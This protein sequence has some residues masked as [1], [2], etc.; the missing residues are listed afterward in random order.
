M[1]ESYRDRSKK[2]FVNP[3]R[4]TYGESINLGNLEKDLCDLVSGFYQRDKTDISYGLNFGRHTPIIITGKN[5]AEENLSPFQLPYIF[6]VNDVDYIAIDLREYVNSGIKKVHVESYADLIQYVPRVDNLRTLSRMAIM[7]S[8]LA[9]GDY[10]SFPIDYAIGAYVNLFSVVTKGI[11]TLSF[12]EEVDLKALVG[13]F[14]YFLLNPG[15]PDEVKPETIVRKLNRLINLGLLKEE[16]LKELL[17]GF[18]QTTI[19][20][21]DDDFRKFRTLLKVASEYLPSDKKKFFEPSIFINRVQNLW[22]GPGKSQGVVTGFECLPI[23]LPI[24]ESAVSTNTFKN[25]RLTSI[26]LMNKNLN[27]KDFSKYMEREF[28]YLKK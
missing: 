27:H 16:S 6:T 8:R 20:C 5:S 26:L 25:S 19:N 17:A 7:M 13:M 24:F 18:I 3:Y 14:V 4:T 22:F 11:V 12:P 23:M 9:D 15:R 1:F 2:S 10:E 28:N 21:T